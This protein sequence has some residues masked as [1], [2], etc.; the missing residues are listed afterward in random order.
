MP[1]F[2]EPVWRKEMEI[3]DVYYVVWYTYSTSP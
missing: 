2:D 3:T 1:V